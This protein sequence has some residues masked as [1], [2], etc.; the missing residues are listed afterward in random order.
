MKKK[1]G[2]RDIFN[3]AF[4]EKEYNE[5]NSPFLLQPH[6]NLETASILVKNISYIDK[7]T[8]E[9][10]LNNILLPFF[11]NENVGIIGRNGSGKTTLVEMI[12]GLIKPDSGTINYNYYFQHSFTEEI[13]IQ[14]Q[15]NNFPQNI[16]LRDLLD[17]V[18]TA[19][20]ND[21]TKEELDN[22][23]QLFSLSNFYKKNINK[24]SGGEMQRA[25]LLLSILHLPKFIFLDEF[26]SNLDL[27][28]KRKLISFVKQFCKLNNINI[29]L[30]SH[31]LEEVETV[32]DRLIIMERGKIKSDLSISEIKEKYS[33]LNN[34]CKL[35]L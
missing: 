4:T 32:C 19:N 22:I 13:G 8:K 29:I 3:F 27:Y 24:L 33:S 1:F 2:K 30:V 14:F 21:I 9:L 18:I 6:D 11:D 35:F 26:T 28:N 31:D 12:A 25:S 10:I 34:F 16:R 17:F 7:K 20:N 23:L 5:N 15:N